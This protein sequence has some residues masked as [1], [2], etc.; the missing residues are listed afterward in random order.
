MVV[1]KK[2]AKELQDLRDRVTALEAVTPY[3]TEPPPPMTREELKGIL[4]SCPGPPPPDLWVVRERIHL[5]L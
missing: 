2:E 3:T 4:G 1:N 5:L